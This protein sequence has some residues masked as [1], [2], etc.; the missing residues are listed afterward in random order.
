MG[1]FPFVLYLQVSAGACN[2]PVDL[3]FL[4]D[5]SSSIDS[6]ASGTF[7]QKMLRFAQNVSDVFNIGMLRCGLL[8][9]MICS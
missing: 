4:L 7:T 9:G 1:K 2:L 5:G 6:S 8:E 3:V